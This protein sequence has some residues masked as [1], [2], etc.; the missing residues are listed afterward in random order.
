MVS[1]LPPEIKV[2]VRFYFFYTLNEGDYYILDYI[3]IN[4]ISASLIII[5]SS[6]SL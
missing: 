1:S 2:Q 6:F 5:S 4:T 3:A